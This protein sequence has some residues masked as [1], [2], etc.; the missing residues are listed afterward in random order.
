MEFVVASVTTASLVVVVDV[1][2]SAGS[3]HGAS[4]SV[5]RSQWASPLALPQRGKQEARGKEL[6]VIKR[7]LVP[8]PSRRRKF[9]TSAAATLALATAA[10]T[11]FATAAIAAAVAVALHCHPPSKHSFT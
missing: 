4:G 1:V 11:A 10:A 7:F 2:R 3:G 9:A 6:L 8:T 5:R